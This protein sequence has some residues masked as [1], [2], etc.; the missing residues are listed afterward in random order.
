MLPSFGIGQKRARDAARARATFCDLQLEK[1]CRM[2]EGREKVRLRARRDKYNKAEENYIAG[3][4]AMGL[5]PWVKLVDTNT[6]RTI[7]QDDLSAMTRE[8]QV[9]DD[10]DPMVM[11]PR[12]RM[13]IDRNEEWAFNNSLL[14]EQWQE[15]APLP[16]AERHCKHPAWPS[17]R[18]ITVAPRGGSRLRL[19]TWIA[20]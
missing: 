17:H 15:L 6:A 10:P 1:K 19:T 13:K 14:Y 16:Y 9:A 8:E 12:P 20:G 11:V 5:N 3:M 2:P 7:A 18:T 4:E